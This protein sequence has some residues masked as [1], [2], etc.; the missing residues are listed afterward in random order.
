MTIEFIFDEI[1]SRL[2]KYFQ[3]CNKDAITG[4]KQP[5]HAVSHFYMEGEIY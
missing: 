4:R 2:L 5:P 3:I 1:R